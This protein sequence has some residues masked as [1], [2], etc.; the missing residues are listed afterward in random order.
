MAGWNHTPGGEMFSTTEMQQFAVDFADQ[1]NVHPM[2][3]VVNPWGYPPLCM[4]PPSDV[5]GGGRLHPKMDVVLCSH[6][7][8]WLEGDTSRPLPG[9][10][11][12]EW[13]LRVVMEL[14][15][16]DLIDPDGSWEN[17]L[18]PI[19]DL[20]RPDNV[21]RLEQF[22]DGKFDPLFA[23]YYVAR[24]ADLRFDAARIGARR[25]YEAHH[26]QRNHVLTVE[27]DEA[28]LRCEVHRAWVAQASKLWTLSLSE[29]RQYAT[30]MHAAS[31]QPGMPEEMFVAA[32]KRFSEATSATRSVLADLLDHTNGLKAA[33]SA[34]TALW[35]DHISATAVD[36]PA[37]F[38]LWESLHDQTEVAAAA[39]YGTPKDPA[40][41]KKLDDLFVNWW[42]HLWDEAERSA[43]QV[44]NLIADGRLYTPPKVAPN[45][46][47]IVV[48]RE[49]FRHVDVP[50]L[51]SGE[52][53]L[54]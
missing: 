46:L 50:P 49:R 1:F 41:Y 4:P 8:F 3:V 29:W 53:A 7:V 25:L 44:D 23:K 45:A 52:P 35:T 33:V 38:N 34:N 20:D 51:P 28:R 12:W 11:P 5:H 2:S 42:N 14:R 39:V 10:H 37:T 19:L 13:S 24:S 31:N 18:A 47:E 32:R 22:R 27:R 36:V 54:N 21:T 26:A 6:P 48:G 40:A 17:A 16:R 9:E 30:E 43:A 15:A